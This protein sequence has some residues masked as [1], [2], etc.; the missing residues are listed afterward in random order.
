LSADGPQNL[1]DAVTVARHPGAKGVLAL[2]AGAVHGPLDVY[3]AHPYRLDAFSSGDAGP[4]AF[5]EAGRLRVLRAW[6]EGQAQRQL[7]ALL[8]RPWP[9]VAIVTSHAEAT[10]WMVPA[11]VAAGAICFATSMGAFGT[12]FT[13]ATRI[14]VVPMVIYTEFTL[15]ANVAMAA[16]LSFVLGA[17]TWA[18]LAFART[19]TGSSV[20]AAG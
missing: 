16:A 12:A 19:L 4:L 20:A 8:A 2:C 14:N 18:A 3:K 6:P 5:V 11:L 7:L 9:K 13:L 10:A 17:I 15:Q 1:L